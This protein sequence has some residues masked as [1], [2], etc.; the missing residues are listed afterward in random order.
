MT[1][2]CLVLDGAQIDTDVCAA[3]A[4]P[5]QVVKDLH[6][7]YWEEARKG[8]GPQLTREGWHQAIHPY[9]A[10]STSTSPKSQSSSAHSQPSIYR[11]SGFAGPTSSRVSRYMRRNSEGEEKEHLLS[12]LV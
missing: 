1:R 9:G 3:S 2:V 7:Q 4:P 6:G 5:L 11:A 12:S 10:Q 8:R